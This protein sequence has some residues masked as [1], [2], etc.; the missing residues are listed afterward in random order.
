[1][2]AG[3]KM[4]NIIFAVGTCLVVASLFLLG[5]C[6]RPGYRTIE[7]PR[8]QITPDAQRDKMAVAGNFSNQVE[9]R[10]DSNEVQKFVT[11]Y[12]RFAD[13]A[14]DINK[15]YRKRDFAYA[16]YDQKGL[17]EQAGSLF[18]RIVHIHDD[19]ITAQLPYEADFVRM[20]EDSDSILRKEPRN[21]DAELMLTSQ[22]FSFAKHVW[23]GVGQ[24]DEEK[25]DW[26]LVRKKL[27]LEALM[28]SLLLHPERSI[29]ADEP[30]YRQYALLRRYL[31]KYN[32]IDSA[33]KWITVPS[34]DRKLSEGDSSHVILHI[35]KRLALT[36]D[37]QGDTIS[38]TYT[39]DLAKAIKRFQ[40]S[41]GL[42][43]DGVIG[44][45][46]ISELNM[47]ASKIVEQIVLNMERARWVPVS[48]DGS[49]IVVNIPAFKLYVY[50]HDSLVWDMNIVAGQPMHETV[51][52][53][54]ELKYVVFS[55]YWNVPQSIY[56]N[57]ILPGIKRDPDYLAKHNM[58]KF[59]N[60]VRQKPGPSN[61]LGRVKFLFPNSYNI[62]LHDTPSKSL[63]S[64]D[65]R[66]FSHGCIRL[67][68]PKKLA[69][70]LLRD[71]KAWTSAKIDAAMSSNSEKWVTLDKPV[72]VFIAYFTAWVGRDGALNIRKDVYKRDSR[73]AEM[74]IAGN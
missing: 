51:I 19:G 62:Y 42:Q 63:F 45:T 6:T 67:A 49:Y 58:E 4:S 56:K 36:G 24:T 13:Y 25:M 16:W 29:N 73:L 48:M 68:E 47:P 21:A 26:Y 28:D 41:R 74:M 3:M 32:E 65:N 34:S 18:N 43:A 64:K 10:F 40:D 17:I 39:A 35:R 30:V 53:N 22:Y 31:K 14:A 20:M 72:P 12:P 33:G 7:G 60:S 52:F 9:L 70:Y 2:R 57:E 8:T 54:G 1:M 5:N 27:D 66:A 50:D 37:F 61:S 59:G 15:F 11:R 44:P 23:Q 69:M 38:A 71:S 55:P 46:V